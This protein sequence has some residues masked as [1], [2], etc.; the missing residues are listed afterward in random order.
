MRNMLVLA[1][2]GVKCGLTDPLPASILDV[3]PTILHLL[4]LDPLPAQDGRVLAEA[5]IG[6]PDSDL[7]R[8]ARETISAETG[9]CRQTLHLSTLDGARY[10]DYGSVV[11]S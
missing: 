5:L 7:S 2:A 4:G 10:V 11:R 9:A 8:V 6:G 1:G 3:A